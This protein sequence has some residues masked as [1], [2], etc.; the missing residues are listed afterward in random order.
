MA[1]VASLECCNSHLVDFETYLTDTR[2][3]TTTVKAAHGFLFLIFVLLV[4]VFPIIED[5]CNKELARVGC[6][7]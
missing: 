7:S 5:P 2:C 1:Y 6:T 4:F 3:I